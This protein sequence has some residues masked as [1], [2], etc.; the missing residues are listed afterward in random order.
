MYTKLKHDKIHFLSHFYATLGR[1]TSS[2]NTCKEQH[3]LASQ[4]EG[5]VQSKPLQ[6]N[7]TFL[8]TLFQL[9]V[10]IHTCTFSVNIKRY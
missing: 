2:R 9:Y 10:Y 6:H 7:Q 5:V 3:S 1:V 4:R 8:M